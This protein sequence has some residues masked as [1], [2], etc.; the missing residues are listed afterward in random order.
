MDDEEDL[1]PH[2]REIAQRKPGDPNPNEEPLDFT[3]NPIPAANPTIA[4]LP[5]E[6]MIDHTFLMPEQEDGSRVR[7]K[8]IERV[9]AHKDELA[10]DPDLIKFKCLVNDDYGEIVAYN[11]IVDYIEQDQSWDGMWHFKEILDHKKVRDGTD[12]KSV[13]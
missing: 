8:I 12:R 2:L 3:F 7:A 10:K 6:E 5:P 13:V 11:D 9:Q 4:G 1:A